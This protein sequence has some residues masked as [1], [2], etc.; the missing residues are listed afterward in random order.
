[1]KPG[2]KGLRYEK[3]NQNQFF[4][5]FTLLHKTYDTVHKANCLGLRFGCSLM[6]NTFLSFTFRSPLL[7][8]A[9]GRLV[10][11]VSFRFSSNTGLFGMDHCRSPLGIS[12]ISMVPLLPPCSASSTSLWLLS[13]RRRLNLFPNDF[14]F[15]LNSWPT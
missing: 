9:V 12:F 11:L 15:C 6:F 3:V 4:K 7:T 10:P 8:V 5:L 13:F 14:I 1:M 2:N